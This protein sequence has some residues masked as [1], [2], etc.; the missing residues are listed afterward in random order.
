MYSKNEYLFRQSYHY[1]NGCSSTSLKWLFLAGKQAYFSFHSSAAFI[2]YLP[3]H[4]KNKT[5]TW[6]ELYEMK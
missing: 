6:N 1:I 4:I 3:L 5:F 2:L